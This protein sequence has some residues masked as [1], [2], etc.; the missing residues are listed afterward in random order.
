MVRDADAWIV[1]S[2]Q[3][4]R[5][6]YADVPSFM[7]DF[8][9]DDSVRIA[10]AASFGSIAGNDLASADV[11]S[12]RELLGRFHAIGVREH[13][14]AVWLEQVAGVAAEHVPDP[15]LLLDR[16]QY[17]ALAGQH[18]KGEGIL[19]YYL[20]DPTVETVEAVVALANTFGLRAVPMED[21]DMPQRRAV[22]EWLGLLRDASLVVT[23]SFHGTVFAALLETPFVT[24][25]NAQRGLDRFESLGQL[26]GISDRFVTNA[27]DL[28]RV[29]GLPIDWAGI[30]TAICAARDAGRSFLAAHLNSAR[31]A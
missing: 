21:P 10:Y 3:V 12:V 25:P 5:T 2:D 13:S 27:S 26:L 31:K 17:L 11:E 1:G 14:A 15:T 23:D 24:I 20:L 7:L 28:S 4:W 16:Q 30:Q 19:L 6:A 9:T 22:G 18:R 29:A 8:L